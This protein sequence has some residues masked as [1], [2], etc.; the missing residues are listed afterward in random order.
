MGNCFKSNSNLLTQNL[1]DND[2][3]QMPY[4]Y[5]FK[6][7]LLGNAN[8]GKTSLLKALLDRSD[9]LINRPTIGVDFDMFHLMH[10]N[11]GYKLCIWDSA[12]NDNYRTGTRM[13]YSNCNI[14]CLIYDVSNR[15]TFENINNYI[16]EIK[17]YTKSLEY[18]FIII[19]NKTDLH[20]KRVVS[21][22]EGK[23]YA[24]SR[25][26]YYCE[27]NKDK[28]E[29]RNTIINIL[30]A[31]CYKLSNDIE[32]NNSNEITEYNNPIYDQRK[33]NKIKKNVYTN[34]NINDN[35]NI[36]NQFYMN[37]NSNNKIKYSNNSVSYEP[38]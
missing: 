5:K 36:F 14:F 8:V 37:N 10:N 25:G 30:K 2:Q 33:I 16:D 9:H 35:K 11:C 26:F 1:S 29:S 4:E 27:T 34:Y 12:G 24:L 20:S 3:L 23:Q 19:A 21:I 17:D 38:L 18:Y 28:L 31:I 32:K 15:V 6:M 22:E 13:Y 7:L